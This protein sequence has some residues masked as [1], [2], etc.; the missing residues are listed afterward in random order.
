M[1]F[2]CLYNY[3]SNS[4]LM[5]TNSR[6]QLRRICMY[7]VFN[8]PEKGFKLVYLAKTSHKLRREKII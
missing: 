1:C 7:I 3:Y 6:V 5:F 2:R 4:E 8:S